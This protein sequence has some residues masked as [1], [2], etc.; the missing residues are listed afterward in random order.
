MQTLSPNSKKCL[1]ASAL[2][3]SSLAFAA[4][5]TSTLKADLDARKSTSFA[6]I[7]DRWETEYGS[8]AV[9]SLL[10]IAADKDAED[11]DRYIAILATA[12][13][14]GE[15]TAPMLTPYLKDSSWMIRSATLK[16]LS[17]LQNPATA[18]SV[19]PAL[20]DPALVVRLEAVYALETLKPS[21]AINALLDSLRDQNNYHRGKAQWVPQRALQALVKLKASS[22]AP[23]LR[24]LLD[25]QD[26]SFRKEVVN[27]LDLIGVQRKPAMAK[28]ASLQARVNAWKN[29]LDHK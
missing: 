21:G 19:V 27:T 23:Q 3:I 18:D 26:L 16:A 10:K 2:L 20:K 29:A 22:A 12:K 15:A 11:A 25:H 8:S 9:K 6:K 28:S 4:P 5:S 24:P 14:G 17:A 13:L 7:I 1:I